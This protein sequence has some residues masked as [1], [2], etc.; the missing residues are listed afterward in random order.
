MKLLIAGSSD[1]LIDCDLVEQAVKFFRL[2][3]KEVV[4]GSGG[5]ADAAGEDWANI[6]LDKEPKTFPAN[7]RQEGAAAG[8]ARNTSMI[9]YADALLLIWDGVSQDSVDMKHC[10][11]ELEKPVYEMILKT[12]L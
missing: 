3:V 8:S 4:S 6:F 9:E 10:M 11:Q 5:N 2:N 12:S 7:W 1:L